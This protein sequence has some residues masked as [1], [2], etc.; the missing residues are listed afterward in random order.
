MAEGP[1]ESVSHRLASPIPP[2]PHQ[3]DDRSSVGRGAARPPSPAAGG[4]D[5]RDR[6]SRA[7]AY[8]AW[9]GR[10]A[11][12]GTRSGVLL[13]DGGYRRD[14][15]REE[16]MGFWG[17]GMRPPHAWATPSEEVAT[18]LLL[19]T[20]VRESQGGIAWGILSSPHRGASRRVPS[21]EVLYPEGVIFTLMVNTLIAVMA[22]LGSSVIE[23]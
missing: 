22:V 13:A 18:R 6:P 16:G 21:R 10:D 4:P 5:E 12:T 15:S 1:S 17:G 7:L 9:A 19:A 3:R 11:T 2:A 23:N 20:D 14:G 8:G